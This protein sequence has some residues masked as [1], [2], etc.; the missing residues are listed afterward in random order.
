MV[1]CLLM[2][3]CNQLMYDLEITVHSTHIIHIEMFMNIYIYEYDDE[4]RCLPSSAVCHF[5]SSIT[6]DHFPFFCCSAQYRSIA[7]YLF[8]MFWNFLNRHTILLGDL[9]LTKI[10][11]NHKICSVVLGENIA[12]CDDDECMF[13]VSEWLLETL[14]R[15]IY[16][17][18]NQW[19]LKRTMQTS[20]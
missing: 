16:R 8:G 9:I 2:F 1:H 15:K 3:A 11:V 6:N 10:E 4:T 7:L 17:L 13:S 12:I 14:M 5:L 19:Q 18:I 20:H